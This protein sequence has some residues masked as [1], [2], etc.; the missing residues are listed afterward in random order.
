MSYMSDASP[1]NIQ[2]SST[3]SKGA[4]LEDPGGTGS[5]FGAAFSG[6]ACFN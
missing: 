5:V 1:N 4:R 3:S 2:Y 6:F